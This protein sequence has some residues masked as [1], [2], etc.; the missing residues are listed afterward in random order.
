MLG[1]A[2]VISMESSVAAATVK[3]KEPLTLPTAAER[4]TLPAATALRVP[5]ALML[6][7]DPSEEAHATSP[8]RSCLLLS[9]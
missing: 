3:G 6:A 2:G 9:E 1:I 7:T 4:F 5:L 8:V